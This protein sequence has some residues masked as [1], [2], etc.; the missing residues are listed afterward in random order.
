MSR[1]QVALRGALWVMAESWLVRLVSLL[2]FLALARLLSPAD[3]GLM[4]L[5]GIYLT[6]CTFVIDQGFGTAL[7]QREALE[8][9]HMDAVFWAQLAIGLAAAALTLSTAGWIAKLFV[10]P[11]LAP[12]LRALAP[13]PMISALTLVQQAQLRRE[14]RFRA[15]ALRHIVSAAAGAAIGISL[16]VLG[17]GVW[18][19][20]AQMLSGAAIGLA[21]LWRVGDWRPRLAFSFKHLRELATFGATVFAHELAWTVTYQIDRL[22]LG[23]FAGAGTLGIYTVAQRVAS[24]IGE[25]LVVGLQGMV[26]PVFSRVQH[27]PAAL[28]RGL[29]RA[30]RLIAFLAF[31]ALTGLAL[32]APELIAVL[33]G[34]KWLQA[35]PVLQAATLPTLVYAL[36][37]FL[38]NLLTAIGRPGL[39]LVLT[40]IQAVAAAIFVMIAVDAGP[41]A[42]ALAMGASALLAYL[43]NLVMLMRLIGLSPL[44]YHLQAWPAA[45]ATG[46]MI[47]AVWAAGPYLGEQPVLLALAGKIALGG[48]IYLALTALLARDQWREILELAR[49][50]KNRPR[51]LPGT[52]AG[53]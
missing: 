38:S 46:V 1:T 23:R 8:P 51:G 32:T 22:L 9:E 16:A 26:V 28:L 27:D 41:A 21:I 48:S 30:Y 3:F 5:A 31:P 19:L 4:A 24:I 7:V 37:F 12:V 10:E 36:G 44:A 15:L 29:F 53:S 11:E 49:T 35:A 47:L 40:L 43:V 18:S 14:L 25:V 33:L 39:R 20:V 42:V 6:L 17:Y 50:L 34:A 2:A 13:M 52:A 45:T